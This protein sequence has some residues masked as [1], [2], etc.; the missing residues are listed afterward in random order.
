[1]LVGFSG[2]VLGA[3][4][5]IRSRMGASSSAAHASVWAGVALILLPTMAG[6]AMGMAGGFFRGLGVLLALAGFFLEYAA[7]TA[8]LGALILNRFSPASPGPAASPPAGL[9]APPPVAPP[10]APAPPPPDLR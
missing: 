3:G 9:P 7:W 4:E 2:G 10:P 8:G 1:M 5:L 6:E